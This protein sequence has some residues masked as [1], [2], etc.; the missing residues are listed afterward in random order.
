MQSGYF[1]QLKDTKEKGTAQRGINAIDI[2]PSAA[3]LPWATGFQPVRQSKH[4]NS[5]LQLLTDFLKSLATDD[6][7]K[8][9]VLTNGTTLATLVE[10]EI[11]GLADS[12][13]NFAI[14]MWPEADEERSKLIAAGLLLI[15]VFDGKFDWV[16]DHHTVVH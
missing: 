6:A 11:S 4:G 2:Y 14:Y 13:L 1:L 12:W 15:F 9:T 10:K 5:V 7:C 3:G 16:Q 8:K